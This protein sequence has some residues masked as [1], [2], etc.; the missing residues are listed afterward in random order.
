MDAGFHVICDKPLTTDLDS[1]VSLARKVKEAGA[2]FCLTHCYTGYPMVR[3]ARA[4]VRAGVI[5]L[6]RQLHVQYVQGYLCLRGCLARMAARSGTHW[7][8][9]DFDRHRDPC[10][11]IAIFLRS[12]TVSK[13]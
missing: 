9:D 4:M 1:A 13:G 12:T 8:F 11:L 2:E 6:I 7:G 3:Q 10:S 5:G